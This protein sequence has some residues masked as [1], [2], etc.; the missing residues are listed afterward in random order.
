[1]YANLS[2]DTDDYFGV[3][4][5]ENDIQKNEKMPVNESDFEQLKA[6]FMALKSRYDVAVQ[7]QQT[8]ETSSNSGQATNTVINAVT[9]VKLTPFF[10][11]DPE[12]WFVLA[13]SQFANRQITSDK[14]KYNYTISHLPGSVA[15]RVKDLIMA[16]YENGKFEK[17]KAEIISIFSESATERFEKLISSE[18]LGDM[19]PSAALHKIKALASGTVKDDF[20][21]KLWIKRL[22]HT[23]K[24]ILVTSNEPLDILAKMADSMWEVSDHSHISSLTQGNSIEKTLQSLQKQIEE[25]SRKMNSSST[26][27]NES[28]TDRQSRRDSTPRRQRNRSKSEAKSNHG[29][30]S[31]N[32]VCWF[33]R[34]FG[35]KA[36]KCRSPCAHSKN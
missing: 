30:D 23:M 21:K 34:K 3:D 6:D 31:D 5:N 2:F 14:S 4:S 15:S 10:E 7:Q 25:L 27:R 35:D 11:N 17:L 8:Q 26:N 22:P 13:E 32:G 16:P 28:T 20:I 29:D 1:M 33:H 9:E 19:K 12:L 36:T 24:S 18:P